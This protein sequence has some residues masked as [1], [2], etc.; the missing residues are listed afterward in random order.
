[1]FDTK[2]GFN[3]MIEEK[4]QKNRG[5]FFDKAKHEDLIKFGLIPEFIG[6][7]PVITSLRELNQT[8]LIKVMSGTK[9]SIIDQFKYLF[10][11]DDISLEFKDDALKSIAE[12]AM[13]SMAGARA[14]RSIF[15][16][17][18]Q[19]SMFNLPTEENVEKIVIDKNVVL[20]REQPLRLIKKKIA[21]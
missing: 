1:M 13:L 17:I 19:D 20:K 15:E 10:S 8:E 2:I 9:N 12:E 18:L 11:L 21:N 7:F 5:N 6:R 16:E 3:A 4:E 14:L